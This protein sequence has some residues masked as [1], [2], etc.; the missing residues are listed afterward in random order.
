MQTQLADFIRNTADGDEADAI[1]R[2]CVHCG[3]CTATCPTYQLLGDELDGPRGRIYLM[4]QMFEGAPVTRSTQLHL[5]RCLTC[6]SCE[7]TCPSGVQYGRLVEIGRDH[8]EA[9][10]ERPF[11]E[12]FLRRL[13]ATILPNSSVFTPAM[14]L[15]QMVRPMLPR[16]L[17]DKVPPRQRLLQWPQTRASGYKHKMLLLAGCVQPAMLPNINIATARVLDALDVQ[18]IVEPAAGCCGAIRLHLGYREEALDDAR[19]NIDAWWPHIE[20]GIQ[21]IV[22]NASGCGATIKEYGHLLS[23]DPVYA[24]KAQRVT[25]LA[26]DLA[27]VLGDFEPELAALAR[28]RGIHTVAFHPPCTLQHGLQIRGQVERLLGLLGLEVRLPVDSHLCCGS[29]GTYSILQPEL[30]Y[31][32]RDRKVDSLSALE[33]QMVVSANVGCIAHLQSGTTMPV[34][35]WVELVEHTVFG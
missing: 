9:K 7:T 18:T 33:P 21:A 34:A 20:G 5:D 16:K 24:E 23:H 11:G 17:R 26:R 30:S 1:L 14:R 19:R 8:V 25:E 4:K 29:A 31:T 13:L 35:H 2:K 6:R 10:V 22:I 32:L 3:F 28:R 15:G 12:R 27:E